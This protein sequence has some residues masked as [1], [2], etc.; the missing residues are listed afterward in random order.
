MRGSNINNEFYKFSNMNIY[1]QVLNMNEEN[2][3]YHAMSSLSVP[4]EFLD[5]RVEYSCA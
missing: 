2:R 4:S 3:R 1:R 5:L